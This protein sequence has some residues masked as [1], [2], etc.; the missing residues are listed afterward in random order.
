MNYKRIS[1][2]FIQ[3]NYE[4]HLLVVQ[5]IL[6]KALVVIQPRSSRDI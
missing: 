6:Q 5:T 4:E 1:Y 2:L 3:I